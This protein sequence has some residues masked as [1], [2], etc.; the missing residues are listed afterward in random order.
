MEMLG[1]SRCCMALLDASGH[2]LFQFTKVLGDSEISSAALQRYT[3][4]LFLQHERILA[5]FEWG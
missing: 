4:W 1:K 5:G 3:L 2:S